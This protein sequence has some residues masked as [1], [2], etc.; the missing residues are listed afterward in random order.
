MKEA[1]ILAGGFGTRLQGVLKDL[2]KPMAPVKNRPFLT[3]LLDELLLAGFDHV[4]LSTGYLHQKIED[5]FGNQYRELSISYAQEN[6]PLGTGGAIQYAMTFCKSDHVFVFNGDTMFKVDLQKFEQFHLQKNGLLSIVLRE[7]P[8]V[9]RYGSVKLDQNGRIISFT[10][11]NAAVGSGFINGGIYLIDRRLFQKFAKPQKFS[12][13]KELMEQHYGED[14][15][16]AFVSDGYFIDIGIPEDY[17]RA[18]V[19]F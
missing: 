4:V 3:Y 10:E 13:E 18:Q 8:D 19:E 1:V 17:A 11:K 15:F 6:Q 14:A 5:F 9:S 16:Y 7:V 2:P 12:F